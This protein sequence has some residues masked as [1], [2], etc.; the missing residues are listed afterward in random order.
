MEED[1]ITEKLDLWEDEDFLNELDRRMEEL[2]SG[3][4]KGITWDDL[5]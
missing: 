3:M 1:E 5:E 4:V 2:E